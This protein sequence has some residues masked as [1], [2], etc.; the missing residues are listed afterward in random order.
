M[1]RFVSEYML[2]VPSLCLHMLSKWFESEKK[3]FF[4]LFW[5]GLGFGWVFCFKFDQIHLTDSAP[6]LKSWVRGLSGPC[7]PL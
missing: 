6:H 2:G 5:L 4:L 3:S 1:N 7:S